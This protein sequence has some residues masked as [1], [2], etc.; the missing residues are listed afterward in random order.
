[1]QEGLAG[2]VSHLIQLDITEARLARSEPVQIVVFR[3]GVNW[4]EL[5]PKLT[6]RLHVLIHRRNE[7]SVCRSLYL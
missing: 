3:F 7:A 6:V 5:V 4:Y 2:Y 1:M